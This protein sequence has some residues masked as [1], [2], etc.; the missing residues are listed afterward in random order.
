MRDHLGLETG[1]LWPLIEHKTVG[2]K[3]SATCKTRLE[4]I[5]VVYITRTIWQPMRSNDHGEAWRE[6]VYECNLLVSRVHYI[7]VLS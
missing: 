2:D 5:S 4:V 3:V 7:M 1:E 6:N